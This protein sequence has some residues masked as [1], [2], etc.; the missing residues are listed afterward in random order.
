MAAEQ[1]RRAHDRANKPAHLS[2]EGRVV[3]L[4]VWR[5]CRGRRTALYL[6][7]SSGYRCATS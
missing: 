2:H 1:S 6:L 5:G 3:L 7:W 4:A